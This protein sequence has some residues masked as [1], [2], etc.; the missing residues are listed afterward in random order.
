LTQP[1]VAPAEGHPSTGASQVELTPCSALQI[2]LEQPPTE[3]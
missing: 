2:S 3:H 1:H